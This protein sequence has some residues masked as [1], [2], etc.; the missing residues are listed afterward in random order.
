MRLSGE[1]MFQ[2]EGRSEKTLRQEQAG[3]GQE[4]QVP[5]GW[6]SK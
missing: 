6:D 2:A 5:C 1:S 4:M 3:V